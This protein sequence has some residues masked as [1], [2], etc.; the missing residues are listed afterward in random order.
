MGKLKILL[1][2]GIVT[3]EH[4]PKV[5]PMIRFMLESTGKFDVKI[6]EEFK[7]AT[8]KTLEGYDAVFVNY[9][10]KENVETPF[11]GWGSETE[12]ALYQYV[13]NG[14][15]AI[16]YHSSFIKGEPEF[17]EEYTRLVGCDFDFAGGGR[18]SPKLEM[19][20]D[21]KAEAGEIVEGAAKSW[22]TVQEDFFVNMKWLSD[23][24]INVVA[25]VR[26]DIED[27]TPEKTQAHRRYEFENVDLE[28]LP[29]MNT[30]QPVAWT[31][32]YGKG[33]VFTTS[34][35]HGPD[36][37]RRPNFVGM[38][39]RATEWVASGKITIP[40]PE[41]SGENRLR[42]W[43]YYIDMNWDEIYKLSSF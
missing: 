40:Y 26:D 6:V 38:I 14:G 19:I 41:L 8:S 21:T 29:G 27:Y 9:D 16:M 22:M 17:P 28:K 43:P 24:P 3:D 32:N 12:K 25:T 23:V 2:T 20:V 18:K 15:G 5:N 30:D 7:G 42:C 4:D 34:I 11:V 31:H 33:R 35:G 13:K 36:T 37:L 1:I 10:G 39:C